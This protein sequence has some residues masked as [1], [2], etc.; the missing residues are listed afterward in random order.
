MPVHDKTNK[1]FLKTQAKE[2]QIQQCC[3]LPGFK[4]IGF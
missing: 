1:N 2:L 3:G 4:R